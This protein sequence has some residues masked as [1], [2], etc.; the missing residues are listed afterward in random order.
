MIMVFGFGALCLSVCGYLNRELSEQVGRIVLLEKPEDLN[1]AEIV[2]VS[3]KRIAP[4]VGRVK[5]IAIFDPLAAILLKQPLAREF[6]MQKFAYPSL[7]AFAML[8]KNAYKNL[9]LRRHYEYQVLKVA[10]EENGF[11]EYKWCDRDNKNTR[12]KECILDGIKEALEDLNKSK[13]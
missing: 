12:I 9:R 4:Y 2:D 11:V 6:P 8:S 3:I 13:V 7:E 5:I 1:D 10:N